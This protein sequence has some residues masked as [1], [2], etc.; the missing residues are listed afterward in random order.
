MSKCLYNLD[1]LSLIHDIKCSENERLTNKFTELIWLWWIITSICASNVWADE[2]FLDLKSLKLNGLPVL[3]RSN[4]FSP[5][6]LIITSWSVTSVTEPKLV[7]EILL[8][9]NFSI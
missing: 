3:N 5:L 2:P 7:L 8:N 9:N 1:A 4:I 6:R